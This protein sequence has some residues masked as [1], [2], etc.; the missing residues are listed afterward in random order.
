MPVS[1]FFSIKLLLILFY[2]KIDVDTFITVTCFYSQNYFGDPWNIFDF[3]IVLG[4][5]IEIIC[6]DLGV[7][8][9]DNAIPNASII[10][11]LHIDD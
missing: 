5:F 4:S 11:K 3:V 1:P 7:N 2:E 10:T 9:K 8:V 6:A